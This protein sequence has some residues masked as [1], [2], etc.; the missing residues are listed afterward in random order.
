MR[1]IEY[2]QLRAMGATQE[3][4]AVYSECDPLDIREHEDGTYSMRGILDADGLTA[5]DVLDTLTALGEEE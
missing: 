1:R 3:Q 4:L 2:K 5:A